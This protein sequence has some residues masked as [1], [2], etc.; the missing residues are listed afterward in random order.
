M[1]WLLWTFSAQHSPRARA[2]NP[3][4]GTGRQSVSPAL[5]ISGG[6]EAFLPLS[7]CPSKTPPWLSPKT[8]T[9]GERPCVSDVSWSERSEAWNVR[10][11]TGPG[12]PP[13]FIAGVQWG[14]EGTELGQ[15]PRASSTLCWEG[16]SFRLVLCPQTKGNPLPSH[17]SPNPRM[18]G[19]SRPGSLC[20]EKSR[21]WSS[22]SSG[23]RSA[24]IA[25]CLAP[26]PLAGTV[27]PSRPASPCRALSVEEGMPGVPRPPGVAQPQEGPCPYPPSPP[28]QSCFPRR[29]VSLYI[30]VI[31]TFSLSF[32]KSVS[33]TESSELPRVLST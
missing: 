2:G 16:G 33:R 31:F 28:P 12:P 18:G 21:H 7:P 5:V 20:C 13:L 25:S 15:C 8:G 26:P 14:A 17:I 9:K 3:T 22:V 10:G 6:M 32:P 19:E 24:H 1:Q 23:R 30:Y 29:F 27:P 4:E 11:A